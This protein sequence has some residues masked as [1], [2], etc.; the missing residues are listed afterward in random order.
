MPISS[1]H[2]EI[3]AAGARVGYFYLKMDEEKKATGESTTTPQPQ[4]P[5][6]PRFPLFS[7]IVAGFVLIIVFM[8]FSSLFLLLQ[9]RETFMSSKVELQQYDQEVSLSQHLEMSFD[10]EREAIRAYLLTRSLADSQTV[11]ARGNE[12]LNTLDSLNPPT[13]RPELQSSLKALEERHRRFTDF[14]AQSSFQSDTKMAVKEE[15]KFGDSLMTSIHSV[16]DS[17]R[18]S[19]NRALNLF[20]RRTSFAI[21]GAVLILFLSLTIAL[22]MAVMLARTVT[23]PIQALKAGTQEVGEGHYETLAITSNDEIADLTGAFNLM[24]DKLKQLDE[25]RMKLMSEIS[26]EMRTPLQVIKAGCYAIANTKDSPKLGPRQTEA[27]GMIQQATNRINHFVNSFLDVAK[28]EAG[29][30]KFNFESAD[31]IEMLEPIV[32]EAQLIGQTRQINVKFIKDQLSPIKIDRER[33]T[34]VLTNLFSNALKYT[35][36]SGSITISVKRL[37]VFE[38]VA[39]N[40]H[41]CVRID[42][43]DTGVGIPKDD[44]TK[45]FNKFYQAKNTPLVKEKGSG[46]GLAL[47][48]HVTEAHGGRVTVSSEVGVGSTFTVVIPA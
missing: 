39:A 12:F 29:L 35:P 7:K 45:L 37:D 44:L 13:G 14:L 46:L 22:V 41:G 21:N 32:H 10:A 5:N 26:H 42:V 25:M 28:M 33:M 36:D 6:K 34:Q 19:L 27:I 30:M 4:H 8:V 40:G 16:Y 2:A 17:Y 31:L 20:G 9:L 15:Q 23:K 1:P 38:G 24:S 48:K 18:F 47:V 3:S 43:Q 11:V